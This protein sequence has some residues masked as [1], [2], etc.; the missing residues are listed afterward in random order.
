MGAHQ[1]LSM[2]VPL[3]AAV[4]AT[5]DLAAAE[6]GEKVAGLTNAVLRKVAAQD[7]DAW[8]AELARSQDAVGA[9][10][11]RTHHPRWIAEAYRDLLGD[12]A[13]VALAANNVAPLTSLVV[14][15]GI[16]AAQ[17][18]RRR[19]DPLLALGCAPCRQPG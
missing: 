5:V 19:T 12:E 8:L 6:V 17:R 1:L 3:H 9:M 15:P 13:E 4:G 10:A 7:M 2:R 18:T 16:G 11:V 14:R